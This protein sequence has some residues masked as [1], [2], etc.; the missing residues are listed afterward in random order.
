MRPQLYQ[1]SYAAVKRARW[2]NNGP[3]ACK[4]A[5]NAES[6]IIGHARPAQL[7]D[8]VASPGAS[9]V[10]RNLVKD[11][12]GQVQAGEMAT[13]HGTGVH[14]DATTGRKLPSGWGD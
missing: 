7:A 1:L 4:S 11:P 5:P 2:S 14:R 6:P 3:S 12:A 13:V 10:M 8:R 9:T